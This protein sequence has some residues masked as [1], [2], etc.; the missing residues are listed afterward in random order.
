MILILSV[1]VGWLGGGVHGAL[2]CAIAVGCA[3]IV[4]RQP[5]GR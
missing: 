2:F 3:Q 5:K 1:V 4:L